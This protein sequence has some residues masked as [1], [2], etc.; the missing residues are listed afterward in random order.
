VSGNVHRVRPPAKP[1]STAFVDI[2]DRQTL[3]GP[4]VVVVVVAAV[5]VVVVKEEEAEEG[6]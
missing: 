6:W 5:V 3:P 4:P 1:E 2:V